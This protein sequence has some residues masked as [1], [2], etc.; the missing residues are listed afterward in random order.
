M[1]SKVEELLSKSLDEVEQLVEAHQ[2]SLSKAMGDQP[3]PEEVSEDAPA[4]QEEEGAEDEEQPEEATEEGQ[5]EAPEAEEGDEDDVDQDTEAEQN[6]EEDEPVEKSLYDSLQGEENIRKSLEVSEYLD[7]LTKGLSSVLE[8][9]SDDINKSLQSSSNTQE[10]LAKSFVGIVQTQ[11]VVLETQ[12]NLSKSIAGLTATVEALQGRVEVAEATPLVRKSV[13][14]SAVKPM[15]KQFAN[16]PQQ[17]QSTDMNKSLALQKFE[18]E[19]QK[20]NMSFN[21]DILALEG[22]G[23]LNSISALGKQFLGIN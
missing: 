23:N 20:G 18:A 15:D 7:A 21:S 9:H 8:K 11:K 4:P 17:S 5:D 22:T 14:S 6:E 2:A 13:S 10:L 16:S 1:G 3:A 12:T 19:L